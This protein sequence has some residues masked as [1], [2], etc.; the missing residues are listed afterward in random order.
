M[1]SG[2]IRWSQREHNCQKAEIER[3]T[4][5]EEATAEKEVTSR[6]QKEGGERERGDSVTAAICLSGL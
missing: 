4:E 6:I 5:A 3:L 1:A 2:E